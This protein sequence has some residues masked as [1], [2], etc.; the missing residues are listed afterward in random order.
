MDRWNASWKRKEQGHQ[1]F[2]ITFS[3]FRIEAHDRMPFALHPENHVVPLLITEVMRGF[4]LI[5]THLKM[6][7]PDSVSMT[8]E[9]PDINCSVTHS[10][11]TLS[12]PY[13]YSTASTQFQ[14]L[15]ARKMPSLSAIFSFI[16]Q[17]PTILIALWYEREHSS[18]WPLL[19]NV[20][21]PFNP[22]F[23]L[24]SRG[25]WNL[26]PLLFAGRTSSP[27]FSQN[28][29]HAVN[30]ET[31]TTKTC[32]EFSIVFMPATLTPVASNSLLQEQQTTGR[33]SQT[34]LLHTITTAAAPRAASIIQFALK[35]AHSH[36]R[37]QRMQN[38]CCCCMN[39]MREQQ[40]DP[41]TSN[42]IIILRTR[43]KNRQNKCP[44]ELEQTLHFVCFP[45]FV[46]V[47]SYFS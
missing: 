26:S 5:L 27:L 24:S 15:G 2:L 46:V 7:A 25:C 18:R 39:E 9:I 40:Q 17:T 35:I 41:L 22:I 8:G 32:S 34:L 3:P 13:S 21:C 29:K 10:H 4:L 45:N 30:S 36:R 28:N 19:F 33:N 14:Y 37:E 44:A 16:T 23:S 11:T 43:E 38:R 31:Q 1:P 20:I 47:F 42:K 12:Y 6:R